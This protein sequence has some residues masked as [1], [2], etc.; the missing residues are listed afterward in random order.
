MISPSFKVL[1]CKSSK[2]VVD[3]G[4]PVVRGELVVPWG[5][6]AVV[7]EAAGASDPGVPPHAV[8]IRFRNRY[9]RGWL[10]PVSCGS[11]S[12]NFQWVSVASGRAAAFVL[13]T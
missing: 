7:L 3:G 8:S 5:K 4:S 9:W 6:A 13:V 2:P 11:G 1:S 10:R 12:S